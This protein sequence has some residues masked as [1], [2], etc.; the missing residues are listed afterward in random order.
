MPL[1]AEPRLWAIGDVQGCLESLKALLAN[2]AI[3]PQDPLWLAGDLVN[4][5]PASLETLRYVRSLGQ[6]V[7]CVLGNHDIHLLAVAAG[8]RSSGRNDTVADILQADDAADLL[9]WLRLQPLVQRQGPFVMVHAGL[10]PGWSIQ[11]LCD[12]ASHAE[13]I[14]RAPDWQARIGELFGNEPDHPK[15]VHD[16]A[17][18][19]R[20]AVNACVRMRFVGLDGRLDFT[21]KETGD[22]APEGF[23]AWF[24]HPQHQAHRHVIVCGH[25]STLGL[26]LRPDLIALDTGCVW[27]GKLTAVCLQTR[28][29]VQVDCPRSQR[30]GH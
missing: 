26:R 21:T 15:A 7:A 5:G 18:R 2:P 8:V 19:A 14:L 27:G 11:E 28:E 3:G 4:R 16:S 1:P 10:Y 6:R 13:A 25:W 17:S 29:V 23:T 12:W 24:D 22:Q 9:D 20:F 30:P